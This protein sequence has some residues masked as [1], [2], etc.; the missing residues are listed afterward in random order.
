[1]QTTI[2][3]KQAQIPAGYLI[4]GVDPHKKVHV[5]VA[6]NQAS[7]ILAKFKIANSAR[8]FAELLD[9]TALATTKAQA[10]GAIFAIEAGG[11]YWRNLGHF[12][13]ERGLPWRT[14]NPFTLKR[15]RE[16]EDLNRN[17]NDYRD[18]QMA[19]QLLRDGRFTE[20]HLLTS[21]YAELRALGQTRRRL[22]QDSARNRNRLR[23]LL[24]GLFP[25]FCAA[26]KDPMGQTAATVLVACPV[27]AHIVALSEDAF[28]SLVRAAHQA[29]RLAVKKLHALHESAGNSIGVKPGAQAVALEIEQ[30]VRRQ[31]LLQAHLEVVE[32]CL[33]EL[34]HRCEESRYLLS[35]PGLG[36]LTVAA[37]LAEIGP[38]EQYHSGKAL[39]KLAGTNPSHSESAQKAGRCTPMTKKG[40]AGLREAAWRAAVG[41]MRHNTEFRAWGQR[42]QERKVGENPLQRREVL[43]A[44]MNKLLRL[45]YAVVTKRQMYRAEVLEVKQAA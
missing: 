39:I 4:V 29:S 36:G 44:A 3:R 41:L 28:I 26:F 9:K 18:A 2:A 13:E 16:G 11:H 1:M 27:P 7:Q 15:Q 34:V 40:R 22:C 25:E 17:K 45:C 6:M 23:A 12:L 8:G 21:D 37:L 43:G 35:I 42:L 38:I 10:P 31:W 19:A 33:L 5:V 14:I 20:T 30:L 24:D 32:R